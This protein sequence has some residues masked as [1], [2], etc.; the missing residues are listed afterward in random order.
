MAMMKS[1]PVDTSHKLNKIARQAHEIK[2]EEA[3]KKFI[4]NKIAPLLDMSIE[5]YKEC[6]RYC[7][8]YAH[9]VK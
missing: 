4:I 3:Q 1:V 7:A 2:D 6:Y 5:K 8:Y 9:V